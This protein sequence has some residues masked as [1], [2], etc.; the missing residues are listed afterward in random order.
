MPLQRSDLASA[1]RS[2]ARKD[3]AEGVPL[4]IRPKM[5]SASRFPTARFGLNQINVPIHP[6]PPHRHPND[7]FAPAKKD[8]SQGASKLR[9]HEDSATALL[10]SSKKKTAQFFEAAVHRKPMNFLVHICSPSPEKTKEI[11]FRVERF[12]FARI[13]LPKTHCKPERGE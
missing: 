6:I 12:R 3:L 10:P 2:L 13:G 11:Y 4:R 9:D 5:A 1:A 8:A 7:L